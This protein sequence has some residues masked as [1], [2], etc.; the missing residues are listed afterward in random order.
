MANI[1]PIIEYLNTL[2]GNNI[3]VIKDKKY[4]VVDIT[5]GKEI[6]IFPSM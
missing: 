2:K 4:G 1:T 6:V 5:N 3:A